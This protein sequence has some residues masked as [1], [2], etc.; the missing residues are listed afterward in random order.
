VAE[1]AE[2]ELN[3]AANTWIDEP[4]VHSV[5]VAPRSNDLL[6]SHALEVVRHG[7]RAGVHFGCDITNG[8]LAG[9][10][11]RVKNT[12]PRIAGKHPEQAGQ[13]INFWLAD[14]WA[15]SKCGWDEID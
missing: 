15:F 2:A 7:L 12:Q 5:S 6:I 14:Q 10:G 3:Q 13:L 4:V 1:Q 9:A 8:D 11:N